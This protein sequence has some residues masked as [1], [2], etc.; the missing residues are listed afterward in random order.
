MDAF[1]PW[2]AGEDAWEFLEQQDQ[3][4][5]SERKSTLNIYWKD[6]GWSWSSS[7]LAT[8]CKERFIGKDPHAGKIE[9]ERRRGWQRMTWLD[10]ITD[11]VDMSL[12]KLREIVNDREAWHAAVH[13]VTKSQTGLSDWTTTKLMSLM[14]SAGPPKERFAKPTK[15]VAA[16]AGRRDGL[17]RKTSSPTLK[18]LTSSQ[19]IL[20][21]GFPGGPVVKK[22]TC[23]KSH[24]LWS[25]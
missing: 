5:Q 7:T 19:V 24:M 4:S 18:D 11:S 6:W 13:G 15:S 10:G 9:G 12:S 17:H 23:Q 8:W 16:R 25:N 21:Q 22:S 2:C 20:T 3:T 14:D 1:E